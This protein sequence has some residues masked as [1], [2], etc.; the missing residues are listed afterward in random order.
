MNTTLI[1]INTR[2][3][4]DPRSGVMTA[5]E[6]VKRAGRKWGVVHAYTCSIRAVLFDWQEGNQET[7]DL[8][9]ADEYF[10]PVAVACPTGIYTP[11][12]AQRIRGLGFTMARL[13]PDVHGYTVDSTA[14]ARLVESLA[15]VGVA[16]MLP[17]AASETTRLAHLLRGR[18]GT[19][20]LTHNRYSVLG[21]L[22][23]LAD[24]LPSA[25]VELSDL[26]TPDGIAQMAG[27]FSPS[28]LLWGS[29][30][31]VL[32]V[33]S[34]VMVLRGSGLPPDQIEMAAAGTARRVLE[35]GR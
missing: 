33:G 24:F 25:Y 11:T 31:P 9:A 20:V 21:E 14:C 16:V 5:P 28:R 13:F 27:A 10:R 17:T 19:F 7:L 2:F 30:Y 34:S 12:R 1:D 23:A 35:A 29:N 32:N 8:C 15:E 26:M 3:G 4:Y 18:E 6:Q 22:L